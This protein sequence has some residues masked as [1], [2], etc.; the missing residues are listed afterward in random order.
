[1]G[2][3]LI[4]KY[5]DRPDY[6]KFLATLGSYCKDVAIISGQVISTYVYIR[7]V[8]VLENLINLILT[9]LEIPPTLIA[10]GVKYII[11]K[12]KHRKPKENIIPV[13]TDHLSKDCE[14]FG[15]NS[16]YLS[17]LMDLPMDM[18]IK[19]V[20]KRVI[21]RNPVTYFDNNY[22]NDFWKLYI[23][24]YLSIAVDQWYALDFFVS[25]RDP[26]LTELPKECQEMSLNT[27]IVACNDGIVLITSNMKI[28]DNEILKN[29]LLQYTGAVGN[30][31]VIMHDPGS[32]SLYAHLQTDTIKVKPGQIVKQ[33][34]V[35]AKMGNTGNSSGPHLHFQMSFLIPKGP[36][37]GLWFG[38]PLTNFKFTAS[39][40]SIRNITDMKKFE[41]DVFTCKP[42]QYRHAALPWLGWYQ[43]D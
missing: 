40:P 9:S 13:K 15:W 39:V 11:D 38:R 36:I 16:H 34:E 31:V 42:K 20:R 6:K 27:D 18:L 5:K 19:R 21:R 33:G 1:M 30:H 3:T 32:Y 23:N 24:T 26:N 7:Y 28:R 10:A 8:G 12:V 25:K 37:Q 29:F 14:M 35:I 2:G 41:D 17:M 4:D 43:S 22:F